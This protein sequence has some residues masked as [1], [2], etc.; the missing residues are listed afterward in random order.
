MKISEETE[1][2]HFGVLGM[3]WG[4]R[5]AHSD[6]AAL[7]KVRSQSQ[8]LSGLGKISDDELKKATERQDLLNQYKD[9]KG[10]GNL[11]K[12]DTLSNDEIKSFVARKDLERNAKGALGLFDPKRGK[13]KNMS[14]PELKKLSNRGELDMVQWSYGLKLSKKIKNMSDDEVSQALAS[15]KEMRAKREKRSAMEKK[16]YEVEAGRV[17]KIKKLFGLS[18]SEWDY[19]W[20]NK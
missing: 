12:G 14:D 19:N 9:R 18:D 7:T 3:K 6:Q 20:W 17:T 10:F 15:V 4:R 8:R 2:R 16:Y 5:K 13:I 1:L 11:K